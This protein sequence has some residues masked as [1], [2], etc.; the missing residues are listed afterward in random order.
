MLI[1]TMLQIGLI[2]LG[3]Y[4]DIVELVPNGELLVLLVI[5]GGVEALQLHLKT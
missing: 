5:Q 4:S 1:S 2:L 3:V